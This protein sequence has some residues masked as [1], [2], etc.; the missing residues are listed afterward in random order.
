MAILDPLLPASAKKTYSIKAPQATHWR[1]ASCAEVECQGQEHGWVSLIDETTELGQRQAQY[2]RT[3]SGRQF[4]EERSEQGLTAFT[5]EPGQTCFTE[6]EV[7]LG[8]PEL[9]IVRDGDLSR[10]LG[11]LRVHTRAQDWAEDFATHQQTIADAIKE[12]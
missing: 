5:F 6:H 8:K 10:S 1:K 2:I 11:N 7:P 12:G 3:L 4:K 9:Y